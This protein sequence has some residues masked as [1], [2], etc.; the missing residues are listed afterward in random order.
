MQETPSLESDLQVDCMQS[1]I[2]KLRSQFENTQDLYREVCALLFFRHGITPTANKLY[3]LVRKGSMS[4]PAE[5]LGQFWKTLREKSRTRIGHPDLPPVLS[6]AT[7]EMIGM[8]WQRAQ[9]LAH[10]S[11]EV[12]REEAKTSA[13]EA[14]TLAEEATYQT[15]L[16][17]KS[18][19]ETQV[20]LRNC[21]ERLQMMQHLHAK[22]E[23]E[24]TAIQRHLENE[25]DQNRQIQDA[26]NASQK[27]LEC[28]RAAIIALDERHQ[29]NLNYAHL[30]IE[31]ERA[32]SLAMREELGRAK[33][34][35]IIEQHEAQNVLQ[36]IR[37]EFTT[38]LER[39]RAITITVEKRYQEDL[40]RAHQNLDHE[41]SNLLKVEE[42]LD[43][44]RNKVA[45]QATRDRLEIE[46]LQQERVRLSQKF[47]E[48]EGA[49]LE[50]RVAR[51]ALREQLGKSPRRTGRKS[52]PDR[53]DIPAIKSLEGR[54]GDIEIP[55]Q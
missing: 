54:D 34:D 8:L 14:R 39:Q 22:E 42:E 19:E 53:R 3:Q 32:N 50:A 12:V 13:L 47:G 7:G 20:R 29:A 1:E 46:T 25:I 52:S 40:Q 18:L 30:E 37:Q 55:D 16:T 41:R 4:A 23:G 38:E 44:V 36:R 15:K 31:R 6:E 24:K 49:L 17:E 10:E 43:R 33:K 48:L 27:E 35:A 11:L 51:D 28:Q 2:E 45:E 5:A 9:A 21:E 26:L